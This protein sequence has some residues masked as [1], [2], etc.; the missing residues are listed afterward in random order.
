MYRFGS[1]Q[2]APVIDWER[3]K[4]VF[5]NMAHVY[6]APRGLGG[7]WGRAAGAEYERLRTEVRDALLGLTD[8]ATGV[9]PIMA[10]Y[11]WEEAREQLL[12]P[13]SR[14]GDL[15]LVMRPGYGLTESSSQDRQVFFEPLEAGYKQA[16]RAADVPGLWTPFVVLGPG[17]SKG[18]RLS[19]P[20][21]HVDQYA[22][23]LRM[24]GLPRPEQAEGRVLDEIFDWRSGPGEARNFGA[25]GSRG[26]GVGCD[27]ARRDSGTG[28]RGVRAAREVHRP[29]QRRHEL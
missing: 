17:I 11:G 19:G 9:A 27:R 4:A 18:H 12:L 6:V 22:A 29:R 2:N 13:G 26:D 5:S 14:I 24:L 23:I 15:V 16:L 20:I 7:E 25:R 1:D 28:E 3:S 8:P 10:A 21:R